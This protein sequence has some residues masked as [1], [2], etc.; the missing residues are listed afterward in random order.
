MISRTDTRLDTNFQADRTEIFKEGGRGSRFRAGR[1]RALYY[2]SRNFQ[3]K[4]L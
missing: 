4:S 2:V 3:Q 1:R